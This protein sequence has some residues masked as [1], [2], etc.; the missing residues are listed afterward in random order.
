MGNRTKFRIWR[1]LQ[2]FLWLCLIV[3]GTY[4]L[5]HAGEL[6]ESGIVWR[7]LSVGRKSFSFC[8]V[9]RL[10]NQ[11]A[12]FGFKLD[13]PYCIASYP[14]YWQNSPFV[15]YTLYFGGNIMEHPPCLHG[16]SQSWN[17]VTPHDS[18]LKDGVVQGGAPQLVSC[19][20]MPLTMDI[21]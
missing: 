12:F 10:K 7:K 13:V 16:C 1:F 6:L 14:H 11:D 8:L 5:K 9:A 15:G 2:D 20:V 18:M 19:F 3:G 17:L 21:S 4:L